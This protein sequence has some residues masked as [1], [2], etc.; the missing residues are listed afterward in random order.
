VANERSKQAAASRAVELAQDGMVVGLGTGSTSE[1]ML[2][3]LAERCRRDGLRI[4]GVPTSRK[5]AAMAADLGIPIAPGYPDFGQIDLDLD[6]ADE[7]DP[8]GWLIKGG[9]GAL[10]RE[11]LVA[12]ACRRFYVMLDPSK[13]VEILGTTRPLPVEVIPFGWS[14]LRERIQLLGAMVEIR[15]ADG[16]PFVTDQG[17]YIFDC[18]FGPIS[19]PLALQQQL[20]A[21]PGVVE[22]GLFLSMPTSL[23]T[24]HEDGTT[25]IVDFRH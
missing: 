10:L 2:H 1:A 7:A 11:K 22:T 3:A 17:N 21:L 12:A 6:G 24:G 19:D 13:H 23:I 16:A 25:E 8:Q 15:Q 4:L 5:I 20:I 18:N 9:G 14:L